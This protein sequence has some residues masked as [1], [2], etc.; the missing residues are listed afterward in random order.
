[1]PKRADAR[2]ARDSIKARSATLRRDMD[3]E[4]INLIEAD[5]ETGMTFL[6][7]AI[8]E[9]S[10]GN[11]ERT[12]ALV[13]KARQAYAAMAKFLADVP[14][15]EEQQRLREKHQALEAA[16]L[17]IERRKRRCEEQI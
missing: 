12:T 9:L 17:E 7:I 4:R 11:L 10:L 15:L 16:I 13:A 6:R 1:M 2:G 8:T 5:I 14:E 3:R